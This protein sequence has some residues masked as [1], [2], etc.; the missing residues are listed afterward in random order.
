MEVKK[1]EVYLIPIA[2]AEDG[3]SHL[4]LL[5]MERINACEI[6]FA[7]N[8]RTA[9]RAFK[10]IDKAFDIDARIWFEIGNKE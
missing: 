4:P 2:L 7:E 9:R 5:I 10:K 6:F 1:G 3:F 8:I